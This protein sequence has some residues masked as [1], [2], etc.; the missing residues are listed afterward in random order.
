MLNDAYGRWLWNPELSTEEILDDFARHAFGPWLEHHLRV[1]SPEFVDE[2]MRYFDQALELAVEDADKQRVNIFRKNLIYT[3][4][5][6]ELERV[7]NRFEAGEISTDSV[8]QAYQRCEMVYADLP[9]ETRP[10]SPRFKKGEAATAVALA[11]HF[12]V[13]SVLSPMTDWEVRADPYG[14]G[15]AEGWAQP[16]SIGDWRPVKEIGYDLQG[17]WQSDLRVWYRL[18]FEAPLNEASVDGLL[19]AF[20]V[21]NTSADIY[22]NGQRIGQQVL[23]EA[24]FREP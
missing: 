13:L 8:L 7:W 21:N 1:F 4:A 23:G 15:V 20:Q 14:E 24:G 10:Q 9:F 22:L 16:N 5:E 19:L 6:L 3:A 11:A 12:E 2:M 18:K 17:F